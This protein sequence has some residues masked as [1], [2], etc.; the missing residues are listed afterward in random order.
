[1]SDETRSGGDAEKDKNE[2]TATTEVV[3]PAGSTDE[4][5]R[6]GIGVSLLLAL[7]TLVALLAFVSLWADRQ[8]LN[9]DQW[10]ETSTEMLEQPA[11]QEAVANYAV[12]QLFANIDVE[13]ELKANLPPDFQ[14][15][16]GPISGG[17]RQLATKGANSALQ[18][19]V[20][21]Q[22]WK[23][24][25]RLAHQ[26]ALLILEGGN[27]KVS[28]TNGAVT[29]NTKLLLTDI[30]NQVGLPQSL[31]AKLPASVG[32]MT[33]VKSQKLEDAQT[34]VKLVKGMALWFSILAVLLYAGAIAL[35]T[36][37]RRIAVR[38]TGI[39]IVFVG[40]ILLLLQS[41]GRTPVV[42]S[43]AS[44]SAIVPA[45]TDVY[46]ISTDLLKQMA[47]SFFVSGLLVIIA[48]ILA[49]PAKFAVGF[50][51][52]VAPYLRDYLPASTAA[53]II[54]F[55]LVI[56]WAPTKGF[57]TTG[58]LLV[59]G[60]LAISGFIALVLM[61]RRE[62]PDAVTPDFSKID[63]WFG[64][65]WESVKGVYGRQAER[66][67]SRG[68]GSGGGDQIAELERLQSL[69][70]S[71]GLTDEEFAAAKKKLLG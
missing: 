54:L 20:V 37:R 1:M 6:L 10:T 12:D 9:T 21:Q 68:G 67:E 70:S 50:R 4:K 66:F 47:I 71:G 58:G 29:I 3:E 63:D 36:G 69:H 52:E 13:A 34:A 33:V 57:Q 22:A 11:V 53:V 55:L 16:A 43:L 15:L 45:V 61:T 51:R 48:S 35:A 49:G 46:N 56:W 2:D 28:T 60:L 44:T 19:P 8:V 23:S 5:R 31:V 14:G 26:N 59:N 38:W 41:L 17:L 39:S 32:Q 42:D 40:I 24:A 30:A 64:E 25:N 65:R 18:R 7:A 62:F 27:D